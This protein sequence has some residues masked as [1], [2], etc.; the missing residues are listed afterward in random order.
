[1]TS[2]T[3]ADLNNK[4]SL[5]AYIESSFSVVSSHYSGQ[6]NMLDSPLNVL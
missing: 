3:N 2:F 5:V 1:M 6:V 4:L